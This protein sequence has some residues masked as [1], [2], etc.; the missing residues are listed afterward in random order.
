MVMAKQNLSRK[1]NK[2]M[3]KGMSKKELSHIVSVRILIMAAVNLVGIATLLSL[4]REAM[5]ELAFVNYWLTPLAIVFGVLSALAAAYQ[6]FVIV[7]KIN[8]AGH[9]VTPAMMLCVALFCLIACLVYK[10]VIVGTLVLASIIG[11]V[12]FSVYCLYVHV[13]YR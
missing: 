3:T 13:F 2:S 12:L 4:R 6:V 11:T 5:V 9:Y 1:D 7:K 8:T 10:H